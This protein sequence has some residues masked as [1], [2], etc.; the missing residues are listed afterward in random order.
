MK[1]SGFVR[2]GWADKTGK[3]VNATYSGYGWSSVASSNVKNV[4]YLRF[5]SKNINNLNTYSNER[6][7]GFSLRCLAI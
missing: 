2:S 3:A 7:H 6:R 1:V 4:F 5:D